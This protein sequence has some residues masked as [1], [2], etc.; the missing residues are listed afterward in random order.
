[1]NDTVPIQTITWL[2]NTLFDE[3]TKEATT[4]CWTGDLDIGA[5][6][7]PFVVIGVGGVSKTSILHYRGSY[8]SFNCSNSMNSQSHHSHHQSPLSNNHHFYPICISVSSQSIEHTHYPNS[9]V[10][11][12]SL[13]LLLV[14]TDH[15]LHCHTS[16][17]RLYSSKTRIPNNT[18]SHQLLSLRDSVKP[19]YAP[20]ATLFYSAQQ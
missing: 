13:T 9:P 3:A 4:G 12:V 10:T 14:F 8:S 18:P 6:S 7:T 19:A 16:W 17:N 11:W 2:L 1:M 5:H 20:K 15:S